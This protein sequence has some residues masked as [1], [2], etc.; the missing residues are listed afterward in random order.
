M[1]KVFIE[2]LSNKYKV[3][4][5]PCNTFFLWDDT[6]FMKIYSSEY[7]ED[8]D[9]CAVWDFNNNQEGELEKN[10]KVLWVRYEDIEI[11]VLKRG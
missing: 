10:T 5:L 4:E 11:R 2:N 8:D 3:D 9:Y 6:L 7:T 1:S